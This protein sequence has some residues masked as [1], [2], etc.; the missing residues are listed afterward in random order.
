MV[1]LILLFGEEVF[2][3]KNSIM[4]NMKKLRTMRRNYSGGTRRLNRGYLIYCIIN[5]NGHP[6]IK[7]WWRA[8]YNMFL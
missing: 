1:V 7:M 2:I 8:K 5:N 3:N 6:L 4:R